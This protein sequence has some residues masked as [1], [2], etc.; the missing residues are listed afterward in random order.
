MH[1][2]DSGLITCSLTLSLPVMT[3]VACSSPLLM[4]M[5]ILYCKQYGPDKQ[6][7]QGL[8]CFFN[9]NMSEVRLN[10]SSRQKN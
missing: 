10:V 4:F 7:D 6:S 1:N 5:V 8:K 3:F 2:E 9:K